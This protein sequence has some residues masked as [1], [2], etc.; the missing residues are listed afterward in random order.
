MKKNKMKRTIWLVIDIIILLIV[1]YFIIGY[2]NFYNISKNKEP[3]FTME[4]TSYEKND[5]T[6]TVNDYKL[7][8]IVEYKVPNKQVTYS[9]RLWF[10]SDLK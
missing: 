3:I 9:M 5:G 8:K 2:F 10:M 7:Y 1:A 4:K 6:V